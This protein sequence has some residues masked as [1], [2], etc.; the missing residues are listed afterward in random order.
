M[1]H[2]C[3]CVWCICKY[4]LVLNGYASI[5]V[6]SEVKGH[7]YLTRTWGSFFSWAFWSVSS[8]SPPDRST[9]VTGVCMCVTWVLGIWTGV[10]MLVHWAL[11]LCLNHS[12]ARYLFFVI[13][14]LKQP[15]TFECQ[16][17]ENL[18]FDQL[19]SVGAVQCASLPT[20]FPIPRLWQSHRCCVPMLDA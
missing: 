15:G 16:T 20:A 10:P 13:Y 8:P 3:T 18:T 12:H 5:S 19:D 11:L 9:G 7:Q 17:S 6:I 2:I 14:L 4:V 1:C